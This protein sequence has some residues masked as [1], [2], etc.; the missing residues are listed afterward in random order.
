MK[1][2]DSHLGRL[3]ALALAGVAIVTVAACGS[4]TTA[5][6]TTAAPPTANMKPLDSIGPGEGQLNLIA[7]GGYVDKSWADPF[8]AQTGCKINEKDAGSSDEM[9]SLMANG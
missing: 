2:S 6:S 9:V 7:W 5:G 1:E 4:S 8:T 3:R